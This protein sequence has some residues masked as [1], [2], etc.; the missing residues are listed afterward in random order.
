MP[1]PLAIWTWEPVRASPFEAMRARLLWR[2]LWVLLAINVF[3]MA[4]SL[5]FVGAEHAVLPACLIFTYIAQFLLL[6]SGHDTAC[7]M[8]NVVSW[9]VGLLFAWGPSGGLDGNLSPLLVMGTV[10][11]AAFLE[12]PAAALVLLAHLGF[13][14]FDQEL[15][16]LAGTSR[17]LAAEQ[18]LAQRG[19]SS[20]FALVTTLV[21]AGALLEAM[22]RMEAEA[23]GRASEAI[24]A[25]QAAIQASRAKARFLA[26][27]SHELRTPLNAIIGYTGLLLEDTPEDKD[28]GRIHRF[29]GVLLELVGDVLEVARAESSPEDNEPT[30]IEDLLQPLSGLQLNASS[31]VAEATVAFSADAMERVLRNLARGA[32]TPAE[33]CA[34][35]EGDAIVLKVPSGDPDP[36]NQQIVDRLAAAHGATTADRDGQLC[37]RIDRVST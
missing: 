2:G 14:V 6:R 7:V 12:P 34:S 36:L 5:V 28:L 20:T 37:L 3:G 30:T 4:F 13:V 19:V 35:E 27:M 25:E 11:A 23:V 15:L 9:L 17:W 21:I 33:V 16:A 29:G 32:D 1:S 26:T 31:S 8:L 22:R 10:F 24:A 18:N